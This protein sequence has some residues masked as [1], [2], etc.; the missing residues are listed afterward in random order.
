MGGMPGAF[1]GRIPGRRGEGRFSGD[2]L[3]PA[4]DSRPGEPLLVPIVRG[5]MLTTPRPT[6]A[7]SRELAM[8]QLAS[9]PERLRGLDPADPPYP[10]VVA[11]ELRRL[12]ERI[13][14]RT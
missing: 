8:R 2:E 9:L 7:Q 10:V 3:A 14:A 13:D 6:L 5:G 12:A 11:D 1:W 4:G